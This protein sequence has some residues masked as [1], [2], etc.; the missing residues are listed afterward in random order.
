MEIREIIQYKN[1]K[2]CVLLEGGLSFVLY[3]KEFARF[4][5]A[6]GDFLSEEQWHVIRNEILVNRAKKRAM[7]LLQKMDRTRKQLYDKLRESQYPEDVIEEAVDYVASFRYIDDGRY[8]ANY[9]HYQQGR[10]SKK[11]LTMDLIQRGVSR[12]DLEHALKTEHTVSSEELILNWFSKKHYNPATAE[13]AE[14]RRMYQFLLR[15]GFASQEILR[16][17]H[18]EEY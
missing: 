11:Q 18:L 2:V 15:K 9:I 12:E 16:L 13:D 8:A 5:L 4:S 7:Y 1:G 14:R 3:K 6:E 10:K 17:M